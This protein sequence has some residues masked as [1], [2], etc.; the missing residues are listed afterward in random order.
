[1]AVNELGFAGYWFYGAATDA[2]RAALYSSY[3]LLD[4]APEEEA[5]EGLVGEWFWEYIE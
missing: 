5:V 2:E 3:G 1:M 4:D